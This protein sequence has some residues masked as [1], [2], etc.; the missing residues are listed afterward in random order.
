[1]LHVV[2]EGRVEGMNK[3]YKFE[4]RD[5]VLQ[6][7]ESNSAKVP[8]AIE[9][10]QGPAL[11]LEA[12]SVRRQADARD[13]RHAL[14]MWLWTGE[15]A[16]DHQGYRVLATGPKGDMQPPAGYRQNFPATMHLRVYGMNANGKVYEVDTALDINQ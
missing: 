11:A 9:A 2:R 1:M 16:A 13:P 6:E 4:S 15:V 10:A 8:F 14:M 3:S 5:I 12:D 7:V